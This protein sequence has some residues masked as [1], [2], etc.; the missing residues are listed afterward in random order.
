MSFVVVP[1]GDREPPTKVTV[2][3]YWKEMRA[4]RVPQHCQLRN[5]PNK[6]LG[7]KPGQIFHNH[8]KPAIFHPLKAWAKPQG[9]AE[10]QPRLPAKGFRQDCNSSSLVKPTR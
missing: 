2:S 5:R 7:A 6:F 3:G 1:V 4:H 9:I 10:K 8:D